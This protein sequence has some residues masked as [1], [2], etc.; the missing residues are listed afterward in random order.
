MIR[1]LSLISCP[2][3]CSRV[4]AHIFAS[5]TLQINS[6]QPIPQ[7]SFS[8]FQRI[9]TSE[10]EE[11]PRNSKDPF[12]RISFVDVFIARTLRSTFNCR[13]F[14]NSLFPPISC[15]SLLLC[16]HYVLQSQLKIPILCFHLSQRSNSF[17]NIPPYFYYNYPLRR[18]SHWNHLSTRSF[19]AIIFSFLPI[20]RFFFP[21]MIL[22]LSLHRSKSL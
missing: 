22:A 6:V 12:G 21:L 9:S 13:H 3:Y 15:Y 10:S 7:L 1:S 8:A 11:Y 20:I 5:A 17:F 14:S 4:S 16:S 18:F 19:N 2:N